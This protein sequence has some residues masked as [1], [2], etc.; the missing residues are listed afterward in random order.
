MNPYSESSGIINYLSGKEGGPEGL[1]GKKITVPYQGSSYGNETISIYE[2]LA[3]KFGFEP[4]Q[5]KM[6]HRGNEQQTQWLQIRR[7]RPDHVVLRGW[8]VM[9]PVSPTTRQRNG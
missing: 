9:N 7:D 2:L 3:E 5:I 1:R 6:P 8:G 4:L